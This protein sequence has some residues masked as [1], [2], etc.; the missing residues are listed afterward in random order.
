MSSFV[1]R[2]W[3]VERD[4]MSK[5]RENIWGYGSRLCKSTVGYVRA[6]WVVVTMEQIGSV[7]KSVWLLL[8]FRGVVRGGAHL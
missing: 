3:R 1:A 6:L 7:S 8:R 5:I 2:R 4:Q